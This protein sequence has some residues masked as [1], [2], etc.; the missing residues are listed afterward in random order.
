ML[1]LVVTIL[2]IIGFVLFIFL[3]HKQWSKPTPPPNGGG[4]GGGGTDKPDDKPEQ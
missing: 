2:A 3:V 1:D 4:S